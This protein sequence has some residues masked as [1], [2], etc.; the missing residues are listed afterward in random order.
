MADMHPTENWRPVVGYE[1]LYEVSDL[2]RVRNRTGRVLRAQY[3]DGYR[4]IHPSKNCKRSVRGVH[5]LV[6]EAFVS[7]RPA[8]R[9]ACHRNDERADNRLTNLKW[10][11]PRENQEDARRNG[12]ARVRKLTRQNVKQIRAMRR[13]GFSV[14]SI[15]V[16]FGVS[17]T[18][19]YSVVTRRSW[20]HIP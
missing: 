18:H 19:V 9:Y 13:D 1:G 20:Q 8:G 3:S 14:I 5:T 6:L 12:K 15:A 10:G 2:G 7:P 17:S 16:H 11:T 4:V